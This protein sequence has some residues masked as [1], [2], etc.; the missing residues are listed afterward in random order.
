MTTQ[1]SKDALKQQMADA[2]HVASEEIDAD[3]VASFVT[4]AKWWSRHHMKSGHRRL[5]RVLLE[6]ENV[7]S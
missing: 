4:V 2:A 7:Q 3:D 1:E 5:A 6:Y